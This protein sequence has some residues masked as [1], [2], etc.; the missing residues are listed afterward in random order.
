MPVHAR[1]ATKLQRRDEHARGFFLF[2]LR[3]FRTCATVRSYRRGVF[4]P[5]PRYP[6]S[7]VQPPG[8][9]GKEKS[10][11]IAYNADEIVPGPALSRGVSKL[12]HT[13][14]KLRKR[15]TLAPPQAVFFS[16]LV[17][18]WNDRSFNIL[19]YRLGAL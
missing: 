15:V 1:G 2:S 12:L 18:I 16:V 13:V 10:V 9:R 17:G 5:T 14:G 3:S 4:I 11:S 19:I 7:F 6:S 8:L